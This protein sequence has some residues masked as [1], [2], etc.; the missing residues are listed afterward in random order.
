[1]LYNFNKYTKFWFIKNMAKN[2]KVNV[3]EDSIMKKNEEA[4]KVREASDFLNEIKKEESNKSK[5]SDDVDYNNQPMVI[6]KEVEKIEF[7]DK[8][9]LIY[10][11]K[12]PIKNESNKNS[13]NTHADVLFG[14]GDEDD[15]RKWSVFWTIFS[16]VLFAVFL[17]PLFF[18]AMGSLLIIDSVITTRDNF[19]VIADETEFAIK[20]EESGMYLQNP[21]K[22]GEQLYLSEE[23]IT[24]FKFAS[25]EKGGL[26]FKKKNK[27]E[28]AKIALQ[29]EMY[30]NGESMVVDYDKKTSAPVWTGID[31]DATIYLE[32]K[33]E[34]SNEFAISF[35]N[36]PYFLSKDESSN[37]LVASSTEDWF[38]LEAKHDF[39]TNEGEYF[40]NYDTFHPIDKIK[41]DP[42]EILTL[43]EE[44]NPLSI[45][46]TKTGKYINTQ[47]KVELEDLQQFNSIFNEYYLPFVKVDEDYFE[48][49]VKTSEETDTNLFISTG[50]DGNLEF[51][52]YQTLPTMEVNHWL[53]TMPLIFKTV[54]EMESEEVYVPSINSAKYP[55]L[56]FDE[57]GNP[58]LIQTDPLET[59]D[60]SF[61]LVPNPN[62]LQQYAI[63]FPYCN[64]YLTTT[65]GVKL[66][67]APDEKNIA[68]GYLPI[69]ED[70]D[71]LEYFL[72]IHS[73]NKNPEHYSLGKDESEEGSKG[74]YDFDDKDVINV[75][76]KSMFVKNKSKII[77]KEHNYEPV[78]G[79]YFFGFEYTLV[80]AVTEYLTE[81][82]GEFLAESYVSS[83]PWSFTGIRNEKGVSK[84]KKKSKIILRGLR[85]K[86][87]YQGFLVTARYT[88]DGVG[89]HYTIDYIPPFTTGGK[90][91]LPNLPDIDW[92]DFPDIDLDLEWP[93]I[94]TFPELPGGGFP[95]IEWPKVDPGDDTTWPSLSTGDFGTWID[96][97]NNWLD[98]L[99]PWIWLLPEWGTN[100]PGN[101][102]P[103]ELPD[104]LF[105]GSVDLGDLPTIDE[106]MGGIETT[107]HIWDST[108]TNEDREDSSILE[109]EMVTKAQD[110][111]EV[112]VD[113]FQGT[114]FGHSEKIKIE[115]VDSGGN[116]VESKIFDTSDIKYSEEG[117]PTTFTY[118][119]KGLTPETDYQVNTYYYNW[120]DD[121]FDEKEED[122]TIDLDNGRAKM[123]VTTERIPITLDEFNQPQVKFDETG[124]TISVDIIDNTIKSGDSLR[125]VVHDNEDNK[126]I[127]D[128]N[129]INLEDWASTTIPDVTFEVVP[130]TDAD[131]NATKSYIVNSSTGL[132]DPF[133]EAGYKVNAWVKMD[134]TKYYLGW[135]TDGQGELIDENLAFSSN[136][137]PLIG[138]DN[139]GVINIIEDKDVTYEVTKNIYNIYYKLDKHNEIIEEYRKG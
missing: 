128:T 92:P 62:N 121:S 54:E 83:H 105:D 12:K 46:S 74:I 91:K 35:A 61:W 106:I 53:T 136:I 117:E 124:L 56:T 118:E 71:S 40:L 24:T 21:T 93:E 123:K 4:E 10:T 58:E 15:R 47:K 41:A 49:S 122:G 33:A 25:V 34:D 65:D 104:W 111:I 60:Y 95:E 22:E 45:F 107:T 55:T 77:I 28:K 23:A 1:M 81:G 97:V 30:F 99:P 31:Y 27:E 82:N 9:V 19:G 90:F 115:L 79:Y 16:A 75:K 120:F 50:V 38:T 129:W 138:E 57:E 113:F 11:S 2:K 86:T 100:I 43:N 7:V 70:F 135:D 133:N 139:L 68:N 52:S 131:G 109:D 69:Q 78:S 125:I 8:D 67:L 64:G 37:K 101:P 26:F 112:S 5:N 132:F 84:N 66:F 134:P 32:K 87:T 130:G 76:R 103:I 116:R 114:F 98:N 13:L 85:H 42:S 39:I 102:W 51:K 126:K 119:F 6:E 20:H 29:S 18:L 137:K 63:Y 14:E 108:Y 96:N 73:P 127:A 3:W 59:N 80:N 94:P 44:G 17:I 72:L 36:S 88:D 110:T 89:K 48:G